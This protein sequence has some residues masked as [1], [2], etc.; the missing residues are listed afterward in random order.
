MQV[1]VGGI[2]LSYCMAC[3]WKYEFYEQLS[4]H[5][6]SYAH[7]HSLSLTHTHTHTHTGVLTIMGAKTEDSGVYVCSANGVEGVFSLSVMKTASGLME[8]PSG[9]CST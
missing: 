3:A 4:R 6:H 8:T 2:I 7:T 9:L 5:M 1:S